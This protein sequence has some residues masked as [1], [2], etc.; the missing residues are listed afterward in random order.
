MLQQV[1]TKFRQNLFYCR[2]GLL[3]KIYLTLR[4]LVVIS[5]YWN[6]LLQEDLKFVSLS[7]SFTKTYNQTIIKLNSTSPKTC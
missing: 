1:L 2:S 6:N 7:I 4:C 3:L 5:I